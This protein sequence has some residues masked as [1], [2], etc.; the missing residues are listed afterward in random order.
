MTACLQYMSWNPMTARKEH[1]LA[2]VGLHFLSLSSTPSTPASRRNAYP[3][4]TSFGIL[5]N[6]L[7]TYLIKIVMNQKRRKL[8]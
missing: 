8:L 1:S 3:Q 2:A 4:G 5:N 6:Y 7:L